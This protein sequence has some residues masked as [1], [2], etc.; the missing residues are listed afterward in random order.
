MSMGFVLSYSQYFTTLMVGGGRVKTIAL[1]LVP[2]IQ[3]GDRAGFRTAFTETAG[4]NWGFGG[5]TRLLSFVLENAP[6]AWLP[7]KEVQKCAWILAFNSNRVALHC[8]LRAQVA[9][10]CGDVDAPLF[11]DIVQGDGS[12]TVGVK[13][14]HEFSPF[15][16]RIYV[17]SGIRI[18][19]CRVVETVVAHPQDKL[20][21]PGGKIWLPAYSR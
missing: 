1:V 3:S 7:M 12:G 5:T 13:L 19:A 8:A 4:K 6:F 10:L 18:I 17:G 16:R 20:P 2:Y 9:Y 15:K 11:A 21:Y 14:R